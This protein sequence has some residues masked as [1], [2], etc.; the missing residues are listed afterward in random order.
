M[1]SIKKDKIFHKVD[2]NFGRIKELLFTQFD[3]L[4]EII[5]SGMDTIDTKRIETIKTNEKEIDQ[6]EIII[7][8][9]IIQLIVLHQPMASD[10]RQLISYFRMVNNLER[11]GDQINNIVHFVDRL[12]PRQIPEDQRDAILN[13]FAISLNMVRKALISFEE[14]DNDYAIWTIKNDEVVDDLQHR[15]LRSTVKKSTP[16]G[17]QPTQIHNILNFANILSSIERIADNATNIA[18]ASIYYTQ[19]IDLRHQDLS[20]EE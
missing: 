1:S 9:E 2:K 19:G 12:T 6:L 10:L 4:E 15:L 14:G 16:K 20:S 17:M 7:S 11:I 8:D 18:E 5:T 13:M 3:I